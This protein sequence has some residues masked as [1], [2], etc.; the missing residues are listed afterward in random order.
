MTWLP[1]TAAQRGLY[2][3]HQLAPGNPCYTTAEVVELDGPV[4]AARLASALDGAYAEFEQL[5]CV[6]RTT[7]A[8]PEQRVLPEPAARLEV[9]DVVDAAAAEDWISADLARPMDLAVAAVRSA[10]LRLPDGTAWWY[11]AAHH[12]VLDGYGAQQLL[13]RVAELYRDPTPAVPVPLAAVVAGEP[14]D[15]AAAEWWDQRLAA[16]SGV[17]SPA[18]RAAAPSARA[19][20]GARALT[21]DEHRAIAVGARRLGTRW[22][23]LVVAALGGYV[24]RIAGTPA[25]RIGVPLMNRALPGVGTLPSARTVGTAMNVLPVTVP[26]DVG[27]GEA[28]AA[29][30]AEQEAIRLHPLERQEGLARRLSRARPGAQLFG[31][32]VNLIPLTLEL[33]FGETRG[34]VRNL[35][36]G[37]VEDMTLCLRGTPGRRGTVR[38]EIDANPAL[39]DAAE[40]ELHLTRVAAWLA[41]YAAAEPD[42]LVADLPLLTA[43]ERALVLRGFNDTAVERS[44]AT[45]AERFLAQAAA[46][47]EAVALVHGEE[48]RNYADLLAAARRVAAGL[49]AEGVAPGDVVGVALERGF[50][51]Y[52]AIHGIALLGAVYLP[53]DPDLPPARIAGM[54]EDAR[55]VRVIAPGDVPDAEPADS[56]GSLELA[57][58]APDGAAYLLF[59]SGSTGRPKGVLVGQAAIDNRLAWMQHHLPI[60]PGDRVLHKTPISFD[61]S[62][63]ELFWP[64]Q[65]G[66]AVVIAEPGAHRD[67]R[68]IADLVARHGVSTLHFVP[69]MLRAFLADRT[70]RERVAGSAV[71]HVVTSGEAL[72]P[73]LVTETATWFGVAPTNLYGPTEAAVDVTVHDCVP[74]ETSVPIGRPVWNTACYVLDPAMRPV[75]IGVA[76][77]LWLG[78]VQLA[79][80]YVGRP[81]LTA[82]RFVPSPF[83]PGR[84]YRTGDLAAWR[85]DGEL[86]YLGRIDDQVK[87]RGQRVELGEVEAVLAAA[88]GVAAVAAGAVDGRLVAWY[89]AVNPAS[90]RVA[91]HTAA[92]AA[93]PS[94]FV[95]QHWVP[96]PALPLTASGKTDRRAL[97][98]QHPPVAE[99]GVETVPAGLLEERMCRLVADVLDLPL[100]GPDDDFFALGG[101]S[102]SVLR[103]V[104]LL[105]EET[106]AA[107][108]L[109]D[110]FAA[111]TAAELAR[112]VAHGSPGDGAEETGELLVLRRGEPDVPPL[113]LLPPAG[114]LGWCYAGLLRGLPPRAGVYAVQAPGLTQ[115]RPEPVVSLADLGDR[116]LAAIRRVVGTSAFHVAGWSLGGMA[117]HAV[118]ARARAEGQD[119]GAVVLLD[120][121][122]SDQ[123][124]HLAEPTEAD[125]LVGILRLGGVEPPAGP[126]DR[127]RTMAL[128]RASGSAVGQLPPPVLE[129]CLAAVVEAARIVRGSHHAILPGD[130]DLV[131]AGAP[132]SEAWVDPAGWQRYVAGAVR[133]TTLATTHGE[134]VRRPAVDE[135]AA[136]LAGLMTRTAERSRVPAG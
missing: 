115:G 70:A 14:G 65:V 24:A 124:R 29:A 2:F 63:W 107:L 39:Y 30:A 44:P 5:R 101:D 81:D 47:P 58:P 80:G 77:E 104:A 36:A 89:V 37:P 128:L 95:P 49:A 119:V 55:A 18:G 45:L 51:L 35:T 52:E 54:L 78:G 12:V 125:A 127:A 75:P 122:P 108:G 60:G 8:G 136:L 123:W 69:S 22:P 92:T 87:I 79:Q 48:E 21:E 109:A 129:G 121:Y 114:G 56:V 25:T 4:D 7:P 28:I 133:V 88:P 16:M 23:D 102:L 105:A 126:L 130:L 42:D 64:L 9:L 118:A 67:P 26:A 6:F 1:L 91:L 20:R 131:V 40:V 110:V 132:R 11:H 111:P 38:L 96:V 106:G 120:A 61:V 99:A 33:S 76:G 31:V 17:V 10:L 73:D 15:P 82:E 98:E 74:G 57:G 59:T 13:H 32:Q 50:G 134:L 135:V 53:L 41:T 43:T 86:R 113:F 90:A 62:V 83:G 66:A 46:T 71:R 93:L 34:Q 94:G 3:A 68:A 72:G 117:A 97:A 116:Q 103:L 112:L 84:L 85:P 27:V 100:V 19:L